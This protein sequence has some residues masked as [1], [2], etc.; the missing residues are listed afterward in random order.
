MYTC[1]TGETPSKQAHHGDGILVCPH[2]RGSLPMQ[3]PWVARFCVL[4]AGKQTV[5]CSTESRHESALRLALAVAGMSS[6]RGGTRGQS[7][8]ISCSCHHFVPA[9]ALPSC[10]C[11]AAM[12]RVW[13]CARLRHS[14]LPQPLAPPRRRS[15]IGNL[16]ASLPGAATFS[17]VRH[18]KEF[19]SRFRFSVSPPESYYKTRVNLRFESGLPWAWLS[20][21]H[22][23]WDSLL[24][25]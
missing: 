1:S 25:A 9:E 5:R 18:C 10:A 11:T 19:K 2:R 4:P 14:M 22:Y 23:S 16:I 20:L 8:C 13:C 7:G 17:R 24:E 6:R 3:L 21:S 12:A 15:G